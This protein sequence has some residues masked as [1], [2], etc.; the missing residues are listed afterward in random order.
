[1][2]RSL[3]YVPASIDR[4]IGNAAKCGADAV[5]L[6]LEDSVVPL[7]KQGARERLASSVARC[8][9]PHT[10]VWVRINRPLSLAVQDVQASVRSGAVGILITKTT[11]P[12]HVQL[13]LEVAEEEEQSFGRVAPLKA[14]AVIESVEFVHR[15]LS[16]A[17]SHD[18][19]IG[20]LGG[21]EDLAL[22]MNA[23]PSAE[24]LRVPKTLIHMAALGAGRFSF[25]MFGSVA[26]FSDTELTRSLAQEAFRHG[27]T[28]ATC[29]HPS[30]VP[31]LNEVFTPSATAVTKARSIIEAADRN[32]LEG[33]GSFVFEGKMVDEPIIRRAERLLATA[34]RYNQP[35]A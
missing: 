20:L 35:I 11:G 30:A 24:T 10:D 28:G 17:R 32:K 14:I 9:N 3:L 26:N 12:E 6:D 8:S 31:I 13:L 25:G 1:M 33:I 5:I 4:F 7:E 21:G 18:R 34:A 19:V 2:Y 22:S 29:V 23:E 27:F 16:I 15:A